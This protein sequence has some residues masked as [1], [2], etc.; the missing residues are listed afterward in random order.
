MNEQLA[1]YARD[2]IA[3]GSSVEEVRNVLKI[4]GLSEA[5][6]AAL[7]GSIGAP[8][9]VPTPSPVA[10]PPQA[11]SMPQ[12]VPAA[13]PAAAA[14]M[15]EPPVEVRRFAS[16][17]YAAIVLFLAIRLGQQGLALFEG[18]N[19]LLLQSGFLASMF[20]GA[21]VVPLIVAGISVWL[22][23]QVVHK[24][25][26]WPVILLAIALVL[27][28]L[29]SLGGLAYAA[30]IAL[31]GRDIIEAIGVPAI[32]F[33]VAT[34]IPLFYSIRGLANGFSKNARAWYWKPSAS[35]LPNGATSL[36]WTK[37]VP[38]MNWTF[39]VISGLLVFGLDLA[40]LA[41]SPDLAFFWFA[42][43]GVFMVNLLFMGLENQ[44]FAKHFKDSSS[45]LDGWILTLAGLRNIAA[46]L[47]Y[48][49]FIQILGWMAI[50]FGGIPFLVLYAILISF[51][52]K[53]ARAAVPAP[54]T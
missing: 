49:P 46:I 27:N 35:P 33:F 8:S 44:L 11:A 39:L 28:L 7:L 41:S 52:Y 1:K 9:V 31:S 19:E 12:G 29:T 42:M 43:A 17:M 4:N 15:G 18:S 2:R 3:S 30:Q 40:I 47:N 5:E 21:L 20:V 36:T 53:A 32:A 16:S 37:A 45:S 51:R 34:L 6:I 24:G 54:S 25:Y 14:A 23:R 10:V 38:R 22:V 50:G 26:F 48:I 13:V